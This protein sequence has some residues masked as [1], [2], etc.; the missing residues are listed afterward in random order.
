MF[1]SDWCTLSEIYDEKVVHQ[2][3]MLAV[4]ITVTNFVTRFQVTYAMKTEAPS[5]AMYLFSS[6]CLESYGHHLHSDHRSHIIQ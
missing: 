3:T 2:G 5:L 1:S 6:W 4:S